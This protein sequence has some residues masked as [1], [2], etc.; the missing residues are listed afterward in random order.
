MTRC[1]ISNSKKE[2]ILGI[3]YSNGNHFTARLVDESLTVWYHDGQTTRS[4]CR[5]ENSLM[6]TDDVVPLKTIGQYRAIVAF[7]AEK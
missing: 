4:L 1:D 6:R 7:Y 5:R 2:Y 3:I